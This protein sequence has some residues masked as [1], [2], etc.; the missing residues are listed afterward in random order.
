M[1]FFSVKIPK[2]PFLPQGHKAILLYIFIEGSWFS[3]LVLQAISNQFMC[4]LWGGGWDSLFHVACT[5]IYW[6]DFPNEFLWSPFQKWANSVS[7]GLFLGSI[8]F[9]LSLLTP[10]PHCINYCR[11]TASSEIRIVPNLILLFSFKNVLAILGP[12]LP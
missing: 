12:G 9:Y 6:K 2:K 10:T 5:I 11:F 4:I 7:V 3:L 1:F 8:F